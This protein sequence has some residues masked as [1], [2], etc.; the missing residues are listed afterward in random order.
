[1]VP[2]RSS[3]SH[4]PAT[5]WRPSYINL[6]MNHMPLCRQD[7]QAMLIISKMTLPQYEQLSIQRILESRSLSEP[8][9]PIVTTSKVTC[10]I[11]QKTGSKSRSTRTISRKD[12]AVVNTARSSP[13]MQPWTLRKAGCNLFTSNLKVAAWIHGNK[14]SSTKP[15]EQGS[16]LRRAQPPDHGSY[17]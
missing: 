2:I 15:L 12:S 4:I 10:W 16:L 14:P 5:H 9:N 3:F 13:Q 17:E 1:M 11:P 7:S 8:E 6:C